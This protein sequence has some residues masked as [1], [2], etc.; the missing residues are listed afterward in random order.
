[1]KITAWKETTFNMQFTP[2]NKTYL[3]KWDYSPK[4]NEDSDKAVIPCL[5]KQH[6]PP[7]HLYV[8]PGESFTHICPNCGKK[9]VIKSLPIYN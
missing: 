4:V 5:G 9:T 3:G 2:D 6:E 1:M 7:T 8:P